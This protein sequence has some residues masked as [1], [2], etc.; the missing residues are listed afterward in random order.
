MTL[1]ADMAVCKDNASFFPAWHAI[2]I[3]NDA[4]TSL[5]HILRQI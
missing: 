5:E 3:G 4:T 1:C 2:G